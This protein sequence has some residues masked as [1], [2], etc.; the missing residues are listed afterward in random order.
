MLRLNPICLAA[1]SITLIACTPNTLRQAPPD[2][3]TQFARSTCT[4]LYMNSKGFDSQDANNISGGIVEMSDYSAD[5]FAAVYDLINRYKPNLSTK[6]PIDPLLLRC[7]TFE[8]DPV[9]LE[10]LDSIRNR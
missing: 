1:I 2:A 7:F 10:Q 9:F 3:L 8:T 4:G 5:Q 6:N